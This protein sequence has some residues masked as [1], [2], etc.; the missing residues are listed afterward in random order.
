M[1]E[2]SPPLE[3]AR[4]A[5]LFRLEPRADRRLDGV[6][7][8]YRPSTCASTASACGSQKVMSMAR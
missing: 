6:I 2:R 8:H 7:I 1:S 5:T 4:G 3:P